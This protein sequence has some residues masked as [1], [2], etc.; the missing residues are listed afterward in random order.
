MQPLSPVIPDHPTLHLLYTGGTFGCVGRPLSPMNAEE[1]LPIL[2]Q[3]VPMLYR[4]DWQLFALDRILDSSQI[5]PEDWLCI[6]RHCL[7]H[8]QHDNVPMLILHGTDTLAYTAAFLAEAF[9]GSDARL[10]VT[11]SQR[12]LLL[13]HASATQPILDPDSDALDNLRSALQALLQAPAGVSVAFAGEYWP[14]QTCQKIHSQDFSA[15]TGH[16]R[17][18]YPA[19]SYRPLNT[20]QRQTW[21]GQA[22]QQ[23]DQ[24]A[25]TL[26]QVKIS[27]YYATPQSPDELAAQLS[28][29]LAR[30]PDGLILMG[31]GLGNF[32]DAPVVQRVLQRA[33]QQGCL[34]I[35]ATQVPFGGTEARYTSGQELAALGILPTARLTLPAIYAR[36]IWICANHAD[37]SARRKRW[38]QCLDAT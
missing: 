10:C 16:R 11:G 7:Q 24:L 36:L 25:Q 28:D 29:R 20:R 5:T 31:Y 12:P 32:P 8:Y 27:V 21:L 34:L 30:Q 13:P 37:V 26:S 23:L 15:F 17:A 18:G 3:Q 35:M 14:A 22:Q 6:L 2:Q 33:Q 19:N 4:A 9:A 1:F 38:M